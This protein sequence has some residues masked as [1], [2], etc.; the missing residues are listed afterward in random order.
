MTASP[1]TPVKADFRFEIQGLRAIAVLLV[2]VFH[3]WPQALTGGFVGVDVFFVISGYLITGLLAREADASGRISLSQFYARRIKRLLPAATVVLLAVAAAAYLLMPEIYWHGT[4]MEILASAFY[5]ENWWLAY[6]ATDYFEQDAIA[7]PLRHFWTLSVEEQFYIIW[8]LLMIAAFGIAGIRKSRWGLFAVLGLL[9]IVSLAYSIW[10]TPRYTEFAYFA[11]TAR[12]WEMALGGLLAIAHRHWRPAPQLA[13]WLGLAGLAAIVAAGIGYSTATAF[14]GYAALLPTS[15]AA[16]VILAGGAE[17]GR[18][19]GYGLLRWSP[20]QFI[21]GISYSM[22]LWHWPVIVFYQL[23]MET[24]PGIWEGIG[25]LALSI[26]LATASKYL[27]E[28]R[29]QHA[30]VR[31]GVLGR[32]YVL[33]AVCLALSAGVALSL[34]APGGA[35]GSRVVAAE[36]AGGEVMRPG[37]RTDFVPALADA[38]RDIPEEYRR[39]HAGFSGS[40]PKACGVGDE[41]AAVTIALLGDSHAGHWSPAV[42]AVAEELGAR[43]LVYTKSSCPFT[44]AEILRRAKDIEPYT[45]C[46]SWN[47]KLLKILENEPPDL[48]VISGSSR[49]P[50]TTIAGGRSV[51]AIASGYSPY[52]QRLQERGIP[53]LAIRDT[54]RPGILGID[55]PR[56]LADSEK[57]QNDCDAVREEALLPE[58]A[59]A[60]SIAAGRMPNVHYLDMTDWICGAASC[61]AVVGGMLVWRDTNHLTATYARSLSPVLRDA[62][63]DAMRD[64]E[65]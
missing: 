3:L 30:P 53:I 44:A 33:G 52:W 56:C 4:A 27:V 26:A 5:F 20:M 40:Q 31:A 8:P 17:Q 14:P 18:W 1:A 50:A 37:Y 6:N 58:S 24:A 28:D 49:T 45:E 51:D 41:E 65:Q 38:R 25:L 21:G 22:Y 57:R 32:H 11:T 13:R 46:I 34:L 9:F 7:S 10:I 2:V 64:A 48:V 60:I 59:D 47:S 35:Q 15:G 23:Q 42:F 61:N 29:F 36:T 54:P 19:S 43:V 12:A 55:P 63:R 62:I 16:L 39:C